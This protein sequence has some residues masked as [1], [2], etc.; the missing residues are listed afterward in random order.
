[1]NEL[2]DALSSFMKADEAARI[3]LLL[4]A[5]IR[6]GGKSPMKEQKKWSVRILTTF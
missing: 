6:G 1:M 3:A 4:E 5:I 2:K